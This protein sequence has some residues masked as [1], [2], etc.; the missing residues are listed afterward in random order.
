[1]HLVHLVPPYVK[2]Q[3]NKD[4]LMKKKIKMEVG[5]RYKGYG[6]LNEY[7]EYTFEPCQVVENPK[8]MRIVHAQGNSTIYESER[9]YKIAVKV[10][11]CMNIPSVIRTFTIDMTRALYN[12]RKY[13]ED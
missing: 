6:V 5:K 1:M 2:P 11:K 3:K 13:L 9:Y 8:N 10:Q 12:L 4:K 7:G